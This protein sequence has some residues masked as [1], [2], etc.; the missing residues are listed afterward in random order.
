MSIYFNMSSDIFTVQIR[1]WDVAKNETSLISPRKKS[2]DC[3]TNTVHPL[4]IAIGRIIDK[5]CEAQG[6]IYTFVYDSLN[7]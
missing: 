5:R 3:M 7:A 6:T 4:Y 1:S 2:L